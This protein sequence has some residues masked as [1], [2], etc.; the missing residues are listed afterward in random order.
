[1]KKICLLFI[2]TLLFASCKK[3]DPPPKP[4]AAFSIN[5]QANGRVWLNNDSK[6][7]SSFQWIVSDGRTTI[8]QSPIIDFSNNGDYNVTL[9]AKGEGGTDSA[10]RTI[11]IRNLPTTGNVV[12]WT[13]FNGPYIEVFVNNQLIGTMTQYITSGGAPGCG[14]QGFVTVTLP[15]GSYSFVAKSKA[16]IPAKWEGSITVINGQCRSMQLN[17]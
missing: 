14:Q 13:N 1:M 7:A 3:N 9:I 12:F 11:Q 6:N 5:Y 16:L 17:K 8:D 10:V 4:I 15:Q 2:I